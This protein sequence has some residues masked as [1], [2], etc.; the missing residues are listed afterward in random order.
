MAEGSNCIEIVPLSNPLCKVFGPD[1]FLISEFDFRMWIL[2]INS[3]K[4][5]KYICTT[6]C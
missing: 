5:G 2:D 1:S 4:V 3:G 6:W